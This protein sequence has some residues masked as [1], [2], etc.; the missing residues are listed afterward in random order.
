MQPFPE[1]WASPEPTVARIDRTRTRDQLRETGHEARESDI[2]LLASLGV[3]ATR[4]PVLWEKVAPHHPHV[5]DYSWA[6]RRLNALAE[7]GV[8]PIVTLLHHGAARRTRVWWTRTFRACS[9]SMRRRRRAAFRGSS[10]GR[11]STSRSRR[12]ASRR[13]TRHGTPTRSSTTPRSRA[14][15]STRRS[16]SPSRPS[17]F[18]M[19]SPTRLPA[20]GRPAGF[21]A[22]DER[23]EAYVAHKR[24]R[25]FLSCE[26]LQGR[27]VDG[28]P[29]HA[30][31][32]ENGRHRRARARAARAPAAAARR[33]GLE[34][35]SQLRALA[36]ERRRGR[37]PNLGVVDVAPERMDMRAAAARRVRA[38]GA[39]VRAV[40]GARARQRARAR[41]LDAAPVRGRARGARR[42]RSGRRHS[43]PGPRS[44]WSTGCRCCAADE[45]IA[46]DGDLHVR[47]AGRGQPQR[48]LVSDASSKRARR[49]AEC[50]APRRAEPAWWERVATA[51]AARRL[52]ER[53]GA[54]RGVPARAAGEPSVLAYVRH[55]TDGTG[56]ASAMPTRAPAAAVE[57][58]STACR[59]ANGS[60]TM[61]CTAARPAT[62]LTIAI[63]PGASRG[64]APGATRPTA[65]TGWPRGF[66]VMPHPGARDHRGA[67]ARMRSA[68][69]IAATPLLRLSARATPH[70]LSLRL[71]ESTRSREAETSTRATRR[72]GRRER[73]RPDVAGPVDSTRDAAVTRVTRDACR[74]AEHAKPYAPPCAAATPCFDG[75]HA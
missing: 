67:L 47:R 45:Q 50:P 55:R 3:R 5:R 74:R 53:R 10:A 16:R 21:T 44:A 71:R 70:G 1:I 39:A 43:A 25:M 33:D 30:Y 54:Y 8:E 62:G 26:L 41:A 75:L 73:Q 59:R 14:R 12:R 22:A 38:P 72:A 61:R 48:T 57:S 63:R 51:F 69:R 52:N 60:S 11:R 42:R 36:R 64:A 68:T 6:S 15:S 40:R 65:L 56:R 27:I 20:D 19:S 49:R 29:M 37:P 2:A 35:L 28:H 7:R 13:C 46:E 23:V 31:L 34:L 24:E 9:R 18:A 4:Y 32:V 17:A 66:T 58:R